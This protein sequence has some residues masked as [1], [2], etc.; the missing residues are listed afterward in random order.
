VVQVKN[1]L[2]AVAAIPTLSL[3]P[4]MALAGAFAARA[5]FT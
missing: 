3:T 2:G 4:E 1:F 5:G